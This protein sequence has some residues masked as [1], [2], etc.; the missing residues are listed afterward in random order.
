MISEDQSKW[1]SE[2]EKERFASDIDSPEDSVKSDRSYYTWEYNWHPDDLIE[3]E[4][5]SNPLN[6]QIEPRTTE[7]I[8]SLS[9]SNRGI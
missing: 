3:T 9:N 6:D 7:E 2:V 8:T 4:R 5:F 1:N